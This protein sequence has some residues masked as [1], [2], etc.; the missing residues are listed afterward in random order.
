[1]SC[2]VALAFRVGVASKQ[3]QHPGMNYPAAQ[4]ESKLQAELK[5]EFQMKRQLKAETAEYRVV[6]PA[7][8]AVRSEP[9]G[10]KIG[11]KPCGEMIKTNVRTTGVESGDWVRLLERFGPLKSEGWMLTDGS[12]LGLGKLLER[13]DKVKRSRVQRYKVVSMRSEIIHIREKP[14]GPSI[15]TRKKGD[16][17]RTDLEL[18]GWVRLQEDFY[19]IGNADPQEGWAMIDGTPIGMGRLL[20]PWVPAT[21]AAALIGEAAEAALHTAR[22]WIVSPDGAA[23]RERP[24]GRVLAHKKRGGLL[25]CDLHRDGWVRVEEDF[26]ESGPIN[27]ADPD[28]KE[29]ALLEG[30]VLLD[31]RDLGLPRQL[32]R[33]DGEKRESSE[34]MRPAEETASRREAK[35]FSHQE[36]GEDYSLETWLKENK[37]TEDVVRQL[38]D[39]G[40]KYQEDLI[41]LV[42]KGDHHEELKRVGISKLGQRAKLATMV[43]PYWKA[44]SMKEQ[45]NVLYREGRF[46]AA[47]D[48]YTQA[49]ELMPCPSVDLALTCYSNRSACYQ[50]MREPEAALK[51]VLHIIRFDPTNEKALKRKVVCEQALQWK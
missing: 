29:G 43:Q 15:G 39:S 31:G 16:I 30:W 21:A 5:A 13:V 46:D 28:D 45:G 8:V 42:S 23:V 3:D 6:Y 9:W 19:K 32:Q 17:L 47:V 49:I 27:Q 14:S 51:D 37:V 18:N 40:C 34:P 22:Y 12:R 38:A 11:T 26:V 7:G 50:Q 35:L 1:M 20:E 48:V 10:N 4:Q 44:L 2:A 24:W 33:R 41:T 25:R 36:Q